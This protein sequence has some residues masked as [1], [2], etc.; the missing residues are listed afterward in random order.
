MQDKTKGRR[1]MAK[2]K[3]QRIVS[4]TCDDEYCDALVRCEW[5]CFTE[6]MR[7]K[8]DVIR[9]VAEVVADELVDENIVDEEL[10]E[11]CVR[12]LLNM[13]KDTPEFIGD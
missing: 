12:T 3:L 7:D 10:H 5:E 6:E 1:S 9:L 8:A 13:A 4:V 2:H 11:E